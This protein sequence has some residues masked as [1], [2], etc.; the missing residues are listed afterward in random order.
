MHDYP[1]FLTIASLWN[2]GVILK[3]VCNRR[4]YPLHC[5]VD[6]LSGIVIPP[7]G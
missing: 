5:I 6:R 4:V 3:R 1:G 7:I 2:E